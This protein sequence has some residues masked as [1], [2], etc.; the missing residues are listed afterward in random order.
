[1]GN[2]R[3]DRAPAARTELLHFIANMWTAPALAVAIGA[4]VILVRPAALPAA[5]PFLAAWL[6]SPAVAFRVSQ[7]RRPP[8]IAL[9][10][11]ERRAAA[12]RPQDLALLRDLR[13]RRRPLAAAGQLPG[14]PRRSGRP[15]HLADQP[16]LLLSRPWPPTTWATSAWASSSSGSSRRSTRSTGW[17]STGATSTTGTTRGR[18]SRSRRGMSRRWTAA[19]CWAACDAQAGALEK[20]RGAGAGPGGDRRA[21]RHARCWPRAGARSPAQNLST[22]RQATWRMG[23]WLEDV[24]R[25]RSSWPAVEPRTGRS[26]SWL[27]RLVDQ[28]RA[29]RPSWPRSPLAWRAAC[30]HAERTCSS[31]RAAWARPQLLPRRA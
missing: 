31:R 15:P 10:E 16:G 23:P 11:A 17:R 19:T 27:D 6:L 5:A 12:D 3:V 28:V 26:R 7:P 2:R 4:L 14:G 30:E 1:M 13:R 20:G 9:T 22:S 21:G 24:E 18:C 25:E 8:Q 29:W